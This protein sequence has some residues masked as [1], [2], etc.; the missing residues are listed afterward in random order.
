MS[1]TTSKQTEH[2]FWQQLNQ[3]IDH[4]YNGSSASSRHFRWG[5]LVFDAITILY[6][7][8]ASFFHQVDELH[9]LE[10]AIGIIYLLEF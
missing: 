7:V 10:E 5:L 1:M 4:L 3:K 8:A 2:G 9:V 6:F